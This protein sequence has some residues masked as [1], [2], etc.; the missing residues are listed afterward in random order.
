MKCIKI[1][2]AGKEEKANGI[3]SRSRTTEALK[4]GEKVVSNSPTRF[5]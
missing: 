5:F 4:H 3:D 2:T 1:I